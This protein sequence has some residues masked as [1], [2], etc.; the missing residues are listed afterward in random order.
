[1]VGDKQQ[2]RRRIVDAL[3]REGLV[4]VS[5]VRIVPSLEDVFIHCIEAE[6]ARRRAS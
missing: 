2:G 1:M 4:P 6:E 3:T 5:I